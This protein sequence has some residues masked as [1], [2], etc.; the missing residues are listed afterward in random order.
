[1]SESFQPVLPS[2]ADYQKNDW[3]L[4]FAKKVV[5]TGFQTGFVPFN[6]T[7]NLFFWVSVRESA[8]HADHFTFA[9]DFG[10]K[11]QKTDAGWKTNEKNIFK[12]FF[13]LK[14]FGQ[15]HLQAELFD[16]F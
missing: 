15:K 7:E 10:E 16:A 9:T 13:N 12:F 4:F 3:R 6:G 2:Q 1:M 8:S 5:G 11:I 14:L